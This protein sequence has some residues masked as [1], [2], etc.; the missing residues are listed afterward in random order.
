M[1][2]MEN[3]KVISDVDEIKQEMN[4]QYSNP[5]VSRLMLVE[6]KG[7]EGKESVLFPCYPVSYTI[8]PGKNNAE[9]DHTVF[10]FSFV[11]CSGGEFLLVNVN[12]P[13]TDIGTKL[14][15]WDKP[16]KKAVRNETA[17]VETG[18]PAQ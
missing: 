8:V 15:F 4:E 17:W 13:D 18:V 11:Q 2:C 10:L 9:L 3:A 12:I 1:V 16:P 6:V 7:K 5:T 14:R